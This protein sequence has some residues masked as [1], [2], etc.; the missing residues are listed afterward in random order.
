MNIWGGRLVGPTTHTSCN[1]C[2]PTWKLLGKRSMTMGI[3]WDH[4]Q[5]MPKWDT[6]METP[7]V[8][9]IGYKTT[10]EE[11][12]TLYHEVYKLKRALGT[13]PG[14]PREVEEVPQEILDSLKEHLQHR[15]G[16]TQLEEWVR[17]NWHIKARPA[18]WFPVENAGDWPFLEQVAGVMR[19]DPEGS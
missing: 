19:G 5:P 8:D 9:L 11:I 2:F 13:V 7:T 18:V 16:P 15:Q 4:Q 3:W 1:R 17:I 12:F 14:D 10:W 6:S